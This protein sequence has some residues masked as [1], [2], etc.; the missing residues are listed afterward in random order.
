MKKF[1]ILIFVLILGLIAYFF[2]PS[3][4]KSGKITSVNEDIRMLPKVLFLTTGSGEGKGE[5]SAGVIIAIQSFNKNGVFVWLDT[6]EVLLQPEILS[7]YSVMILP[8]SIGYHDGD[9]KYSLT[10][11]SD[12]EMENIERWVENGG[13][14]ITEGNI[15]RNNLEGGDRADLYNELNPE[16]WKLSEVFGI[17]MKERDLN[18]FSIEE[19]DLKI[20]SGRIKEPIAENEWV[21]IP[22]EIISDKVK[23][24][25]EWVNGDERIPAIIQNEY[26]K[27]KAVFLTSTYLLHPSTDGGVSSIEQIERFYDY[28]LENVNHGLSGKIQVNPWPSGFSY[29]FCVTF[30][31]EGQIDRFNKIVR[32]LKSENLPATFFIDSSFSEEK[33]KILDEYKNITLQSNLYS[34][35]DFSEAGHVDISRV[36]IMNEQKFNKI[37]SGLRFPYNNANFWGLLFADDKGYIYD[38]S[39]GVDQLTSYTGSVIPYNIPVARDSYYKTLNLLEICPIKNNDKFFYEKSEKGEEYADDLQRSDAQLFEKYLLDFFEFVVDKNNGIMV[40]EGNPDYTGFSD[41]TMLPLKL[42]SDTLKTKNC[43]ITTLDEAADFRNKLRDLSVN[44]SGS[45]K[46]VKLK[47]NLPEDVSIEDLSFKLSSMP[48]KVIS[49]GK[50]ELNEA[51]GNYYLTSDVKNGDEIIITY[52]S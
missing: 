43:W 48:E 23:V 19:K 38:S 27:G 2:I 24:L 37:F 5:L 44:V 52:P 6:R 26:G 46:D 50:Y 31:S 15:G 22:T 28:I 40:Y 20:W 16:T 3:L 51:R 18:G 39:I 17:K 36:I 14:L 34:K 10:F 25:A 30:N 35:K 7:R 49:T 41:L 42:I 47:I 11:L 4:T 13:T 29:V 12:F 32:F 9:R 8:T 1:I 33:K 21:L 45:G